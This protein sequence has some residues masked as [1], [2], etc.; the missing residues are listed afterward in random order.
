MR[1]SAADARGDGDVG[2]ATPP[3]APLVSVLITAHNRPDDLRTTFRELRRQTYAPLEVL[4][5][6][7]ASS[8]DLESI[9]RA[10]WPEARFWR[11]AANRGAHAS[12]TFG[13]AAARGTYILTLDDDSSPV[14][15]DAIGRAVARFAHDPALGILA[16]RVHEGL[17]PPPADLP[18]DHERY[19]HAFINCGQMMR[20]VVARQ[21]G[22]YRDF[23]VYY[24]EESEFALRAIGRGWRIL[25]DPT[26]LVQHRVSPI[27]RS[28]PR[29][30]AYSF[31]NMAWTTLLDLPFPRAL[32]ELVWK[33]ATGG[34]ELVRQGQ[35]RWAI[36]AIASFVRGLPRVARERTPIPRAAVRVYDALRFRDVVSPEFLD[37]PPATTWRDRWAWFHRV[38]RSRRRGAAAWSRDQR[39]IGVATW[40]TRR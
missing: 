32:G 9:V 14:D 28:N 8:A 38:F 21:L 15:P 12:R 25:Y 40:T 10:E 23:F 2:A 24:A 17:E 1:A 34:I 39:A 31:R 36:W 19:V 5:V 35:P 3:P 26:L 18:A 33:L 22:G 11:N 7:D 20:T 4:V 6:D 16:F 13:M 27:G 30:V 29:I 37:A